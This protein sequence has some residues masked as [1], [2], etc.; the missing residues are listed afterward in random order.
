[1]KIGEWERDRVIRIT[2]K[3]LRDIMGDRHPDIKRQNAEQVERFKRKF[4]TRLNGEHKPAEKCELLYEVTK[5]KR[6]CQQRAEGRPGIPSENVPTGLIALVPKL[7]G[8]LN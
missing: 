2:H 5:G 1:M 8:S 6:D 4:V 7:G 3:Q